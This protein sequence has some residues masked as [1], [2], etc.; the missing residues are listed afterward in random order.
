M[1]RSKVNTTALNAILESGF[2]VTIFREAEVSCPIKRNNL[3]NKRINFPENVKSHYIGT[4]AEISVFFMFLMLL[5]VTNN[6]FRFSSP[7]PPENA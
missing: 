3:R 7:P 5:E 4:Y 2:F 6:G 1:F